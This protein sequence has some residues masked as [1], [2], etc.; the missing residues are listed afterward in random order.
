MFLDIC[1][2][3]VEILCARMSACILGLWEQ[4]LG[5]KYNSNSKNNFYQSDAEFT[6]LLECES[7][8]MCWLL[9]N[10][11]LFSTPLRFAGIKR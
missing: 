4:I 9:V 10:L 11:N 2:L 1:P 8:Q 3:A 5:V 7:L 6:S